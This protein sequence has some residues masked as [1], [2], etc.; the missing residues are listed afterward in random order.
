MPSHVLYEVPVGDL[1]AEFFQKIQEHLGVLVG[2]PK[3]KAAP[4]PAPADT[5]AVTEAAPA[6]G[7]S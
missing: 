6:A 7:N 5:V 3:P 1:N 4:T 2:T